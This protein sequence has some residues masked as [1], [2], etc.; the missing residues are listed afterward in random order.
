M[1]DDKNKDGW[2]NLSWKEKVQICQQGAAHEDNLL[3]TYV[4]LFIAIEA[5]FFAF[6]LSVNLVCWLN[7][8]I[9]GLAIYFTLRFVRIFH[10]SGCKVDHWGK[11][12]Y[13]LWTE[14]GDNDSDLLDIAKVYTGCVD[15]SVKNWKNI[16]FGWGT[17]REKLYYF[18]WGYARRLIT[19][20]IPIIVIV[21]WIVVII[22][23]VHFR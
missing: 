15:R 8:I 3:S 6:V 17:R 23:S 12:L 2:Q 11:I 7:I 5:M 9:A 1:V 16:I 10:K 20:F 4:T 14:V 21:S 13:S 18:F 19:T 22:I